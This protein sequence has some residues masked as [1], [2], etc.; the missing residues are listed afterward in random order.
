MVL[1][2]TKA[3]PTA[4]VLPEAVWRPQA[5]AHSARVL[6]LLE[7]GFVPVESQT[8]RR[9]SL[10]PGFK[11]DGFRALDKSHGNCSTF[12]PTAFRPGIYELV[13]ASDATTEGWS[14]RIPVATAERSRRQRSITFCTTTTT[15]RARK[16]TLRIR[17]TQDCARAL[18][19]RV[20]RISHHLLI[21]GPSWIPPPQ[22]RAASRAGQVIATRFELSTSLQPFIPPLRPLLRPPL[23]LP[24]RPPLLPPLRPM[25]SQTAW[26]SN[27]SRD[28]PSANE[29]YESLPRQPDPAPRF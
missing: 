12:E 25:W 10:K 11:D 13:E 22:A 17:R 5:D 6:A 26:R 15:S 14:V 21:L 28:S 16:V 7:P 24:L 2:G 8:L 4:L 18:L 29:S 3:A 19:P 23:R 9:S 20:P 1:A 27:P